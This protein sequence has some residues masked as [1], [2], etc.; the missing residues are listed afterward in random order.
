MNITKSTSIQELLEFRGSKPL[1]SLRV[2]LDVRQV[3]DSL[4]RNRI[5]G[6]PIVDRNDNDL[7]V[8]TERDSNRFL[9]LG[10][11]P[12]EVLVS[13]VM[14]KIATVKKTP[15]GLTVVQLVKDMA[16]RRHGFITDGNGNTK[17]LLTHR[18]ILNFVFAD[19]LD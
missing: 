4:F 3:A 17:T 14:T 8:Y 10:G 12:D 11:D 1:I 2:D 7:G 6:V 18:D 13:E 19:L 15:A 9:A 5:S 16:G